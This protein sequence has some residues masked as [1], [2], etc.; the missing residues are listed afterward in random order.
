[1]ELSTVRTRESKINKRIY[2]ID[3]RVFDEEILA[4][5]QTSFT[6]SAAAVLLFTI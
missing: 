3:F 5:P 6:L 4:P 2:K 1:M